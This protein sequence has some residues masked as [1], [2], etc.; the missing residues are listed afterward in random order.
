VTKTEDVAFVAGATGY[1]GNEVVSALRGRGIRT[2]AHVRPDSSSLEHWRTR[3][4][5]IGAEVDT[6]RWEADEM[7]ATLA[8]LRPTLVFALLGTTRARGRAEAR[9][10]LEASTYEKVDYGMTAML[11]HAASLLEPRPRFVYLSSLGA[12]PSRPGS[13]LHARWQVEQ[14]LTA[15]D[16]PYLIA[17]PSIITGPD[18]PEE[19]PG[20]SIAAAIADRALGLAGAL[21]ATRVRDRYRSTSAQVLA[22]ALVRLALDPPSNRAVVESE[23]LR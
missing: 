7:D 19:R 16:L 4:E 6:T 1:T 17:R 9:A 8:R 10:G 5:D 2:I 13:Y 23:E 18:R 14:E 20:E 15:G 21:G 11:M 12:R 3:F 22:R